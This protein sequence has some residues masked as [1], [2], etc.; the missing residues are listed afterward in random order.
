MDVRRGMPADAG[1]IADAFIPSFESLTFL[2]RL[3][4]HEEHRAH[5]RD[6]VLGEQEVW[7]A[8]LDGRISGFAALAG[9]M[10]T[11]LY[12]HPG[13]QGRGAGGVLLAKAKERRPDGFT[14]W[15]FQQNV[16]A[17]R[18]YERHGCR[19]VRLTDGSGNEEKTP[20][21]LYEWRPD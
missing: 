11:N 6:T 15:V 13:R 8:E 7:V 14:F 20:D 3:H 16:H 1:A 12:V 10:L 5:I 19:V 2:P 18:F 17:R 9:D 21:A 4:S